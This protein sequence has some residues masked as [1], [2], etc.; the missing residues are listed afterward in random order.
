MIRSPSVIHDLSVA[1]QNIENVFHKN[2]HIQ[3]HLAFNFSLDT[4]LVEH[5]KN[6]FSSFLK[7]EFKAW[8]QDTRYK[9]KHI[10][11]ED[12]IYHSDRE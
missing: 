4:N 3:K 2:V 12:K 6:Y 9:E 8:S 10:A 11:V 5:K 1:F 7:H